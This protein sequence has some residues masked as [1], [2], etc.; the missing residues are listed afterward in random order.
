MFHSYEL[1]HGEQEKTPISQTSRRFRELDAESLHRC[2]MVQYAQSYGV[3]F[4]FLTFSP[5]FGGPIFFGIDALNS[6]PS[7]SKVTKQIENPPPYDFA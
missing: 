1:V 6:D 7:K 5:F 4:D 2:S 3:V